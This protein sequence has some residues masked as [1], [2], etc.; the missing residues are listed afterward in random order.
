MNRAVSTLLTLA[1]LLCTGCCRGSELTD[2]DNGPELYTV[3]DCGIAV[4]SG[5]PW[6]L[7]DALPGR[8]PDFKGTYS[9]ELG[10]LELGAICWQIMPGRRPDIRHTYA[11]VLT[12][13]RARGI[14]VTVL[15]KID[16]TLLSVQAQNS[17]A[18]PSS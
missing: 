5:G 11:A 7:D 9:A 10:T 4:P 1:L 14:E 3:G 16:T 13:M 18:K 8:H 15:E 12:G 6:R 17:E 2:G